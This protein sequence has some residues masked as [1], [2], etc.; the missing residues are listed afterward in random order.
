[1]QRLAANPS[2]RI[3]VPV[4]T[5]VI[6][7]VEAWS[8]LGCP[9]DLGVSPDEFLKEKTAK[10]GEILR[11][12][13]GEPDWKWRV[14]PFNPDGSKEFPPG[15]YFMRHGETDSVQEARATAHQ[16][17]TAQLVAHVRAGKWKEAKET[18]KSAVGNGLLSEEEAGNAVDLALPNADDAERLPADQLLSAVSAAGPQ[19]QQELLPVLQRRLGTMQDMSPEAQQAIRTHLGRIRSQAITPVVSR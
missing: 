15:I 14:K 3:V 19:K 2:D 1:M 8:A 6:R 13:P 11:F 4:S 12:A 9:D 5:Q 17:A 18:A 16:K 10:P 7:L